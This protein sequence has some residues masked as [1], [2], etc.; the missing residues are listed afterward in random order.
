MRILFV[1]HYALPHIGGIETSLDSLASGL[2]ERGHAVTYLASSSLRPAERGSPLPERPYRRVLVPAWNG[3]E[4]L[5]GVPYPLFAPALRAALRREVPAADVVHAHGF[6]YLG[7]V[8]G[9]AE[10]A[11]NGRAAVLTEHVGHVEYAN[12]LLDA[13]QA[14]AIGTLGRWCARRADALVT[15]NE[16]VRDE[17]AA[18]APGVRLEWIGNG[19]DTERFRPARDGERERLRAELGW[20]ERPRALF[21]GRRVAKK[22]LD[23][24]LA[25]VAAGAG[26]FE[27][28][29]AGTD[30]IDGATPDGVELLGHV[31]PDR[32]PELY[33]AA[34]AMVLTSHGEGFPMAI[35]E[36]MASGLPVVL[37]EDPA[38]RDHLRGAGPGAAELVPAEPA[39]LAA[40]VRAVVADAERRAAAGAAAVE[41]ARRAFSSGPVADAHERLYESLTYTRAPS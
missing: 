41:H 22:G 11:R 25:A 7:S 13:V 27:L 39:A 8:L 37:A 2:A 26:E 17:L 15:F 35:Q 16:K 24:A 21:V 12:P 6:L 34:D 30:R 10:A 3:P 20:D 38:Y 19:I 33:R 23:R 14:A 1:A 31:D 32:M 29:V 28:V 40:A 36:A 18:L 5:A 9:L 4:E